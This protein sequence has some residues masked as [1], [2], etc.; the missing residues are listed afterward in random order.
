[1]SSRA[2][3][4]PDGEGGP[5][6]LER[7]ARA[8]VALEDDPLALKAGDGEAQIGR[9]VTEIGHLRLGFAEAR[10]QLARRLARH[11]LRGFSVGHVPSDR[12]LEE[13]G[14]VYDREPRVL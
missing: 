11:P 10:A 7:R 5:S 1:M 4:W 13:P 9:F 3:S 8:P 12:D 2:R 6:G 14:L